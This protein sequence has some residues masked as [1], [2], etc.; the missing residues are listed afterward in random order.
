MKQVYLSVFLVMVLGGCA[1]L[2]H[3][4]YTACNGQ[5]LCTAYGT[6]AMVGYSAAYALNHDKITRQQAMDIKRKLG[7]VHDA[8]NA[9]RLAVMDGR[10]DASTYN[11]LAAVRAALVAIMQQLPEAP[12]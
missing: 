8:L 2:Q 9:L 11:K 3:S 7:Q 6:Y 4:P 1:S 12:K 5:P 10:A